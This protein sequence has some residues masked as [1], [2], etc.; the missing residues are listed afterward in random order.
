MLTEVRIFGSVSELGGHG[1]ED[2]T[3]L[4]LPSDLWAKYFPQNLSRC[5]ESGSVRTRI[6][7]PDPDPTLISATKVTGKENLTKYAF[8]LGP[9]R[10]TDKENQ[11][12]M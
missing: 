12:K 2:P 5:C 8:W 9:G 10:P 3:I 7:F 1:S 4:P 11:V 6:I